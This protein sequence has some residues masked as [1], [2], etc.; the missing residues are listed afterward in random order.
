MK[1]SGRVV[2]VTGANKGI[3]YHI[4]AQLLASRQF[5]RIILGCRNE[6]LGLAAAKSLGD[7]AEYAPLDLASAKSIER[8][9]EFMNKTVGRCDGLVNN[10][11]F[12]FKSTDTTPFEGQTAP[13]LA[14]NF[15]ATVALTD[16]LLPLLRRGQQPFIVNVAS[17]AG[18]LKQIKSSSLREQ[19][20]SPNLTRPQL[21]GLVEKFAA[22]VQAGKHREE[23]WGSSNYG[24]SKL[25]LIAYT[26]LVAREE[27]AAG[28]RSNCCCPGYCDTDMTSHEGPRPPAEGAKNAAILALLPSDSDWNGVFVQDQQ[29]SQW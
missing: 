28:V 11:A 26:K 27:A 8:F 7:G 9:A 1:G 19:F 3:G 24:L 29:L 4:A 22:D 21:I 16:R 12:A 13:T 23:G 6:E 17:M 25:A 15:F 2:V 5:E 10:A 14:V 20:T 18:A